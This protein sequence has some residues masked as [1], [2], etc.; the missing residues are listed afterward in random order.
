VW[1][2]L[3]L[4]AKETLVRQ[5]AKALLALFRRRF[6]EVGSLY[7]GDNASFEVGPV[8][9]PPFFQM[10]DGECRFPS[11]D[12]LD[13]SRFRGPFSRA[14]DYLSCLVEAESYIVEQRRDIILQKLDGGEARLALAER[15]LD[16]AARLAKAYPGD[17]SVGLD[18]SISDANKPFSMRLDDLQLPNIMVRVISPLASF[19]PN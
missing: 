12:P 19:I 17:I 3:D 7:M 14:P 6:S 8:V 18:P 1:D 10:I 16:K 9:A 13:L 2:T 4:E 11:S 5:V 15:V